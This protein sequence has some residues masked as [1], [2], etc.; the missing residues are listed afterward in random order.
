[1]QKRSSY[2]KPT[3]FCG[4]DQT[5]VLR[6]FI[7]RGFWGEDQKKSSLRES[8]NLRVIHE[9][10]SFTLQ[11]VYNK[12]KKTKRRKRISWRPNFW[13]RPIGWKPLDENNGEWVL[14][15]ILALFTVQTFA[16]QIEVGP[17]PA[18]GSTLPFDYTKKVETS[19]PPSFYCTSACGI[20]LKNSIC[21]AKSILIYNSSCTCH[22][23]IQTL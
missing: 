21:E 10:A 23:P 9:S 5:R 1:M 20:R 17:V 7:C 15:T 11:Y 3:N 22:L 16:S 2:R 14:A 8:T 13:S 12:K 4:F 18:M 19:Q 6:K